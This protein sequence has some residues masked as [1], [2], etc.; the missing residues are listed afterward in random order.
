MM[1]IIQINDDDQAVELASRPI[2]DDYLYNDEVD[3]LPEYRPV[4]YGLASQ[5]L[6]DIVKRYWQRLFSQS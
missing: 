6:A 4:I 3:V 2:E 5:S 1:K